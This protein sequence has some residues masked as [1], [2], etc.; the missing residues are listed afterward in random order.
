[1]LELGLL[2]GME[3]LLLRRE[4]CLVAEGGT[5][6]ICESL[7]TVTTLLFLSLS[8]PILGAPELIVLSSLT[9]FILPLSLLVVT[10]PG[11]SMIGANGS[12]LTRAGVV[13]ADSDV[14]G[15]NGSSVWLLA[16]LTEVLLV[17][18][19][20]GSQVALDPPDGPLLE[21]CCPRGLIKRAMEPG[22]PG[23]AGGVKN[24]SFSS[25][26]VVRAS[27]T[28][29][30]LKTLSDSLEVLGWEGGVGS[31]ALTSI[32]VTLLGRGEGEVG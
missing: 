31:E 12:T 3:E 15:L 32:T 21:I 29:A 24:T 19:A 10:A 5:I 1:M 18:G 30:K 9:A 8:F 27:L 23:V 26:L 16:V 2:D 7:D 11:V 22:K 14:I 28:K 25:P 6:L 20:N 13:L 4:T 17:H